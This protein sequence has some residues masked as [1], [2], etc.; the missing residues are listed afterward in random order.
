MM[1]RDR[2]TGKRKREQ[3]EKQTGVILKKH[4]CWGLPAG[5]KRKIPNMIRGLEQKEKEA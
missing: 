2:V 5:F 3:S 4:M 1:E